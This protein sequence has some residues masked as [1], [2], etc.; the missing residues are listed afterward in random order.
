MML[1]CAKWQPDGVVH[2]RGDRGL[3]RRTTNHAGRSTPLFGPGDHD[4]ADA[5][6]RVPP[7]SAADR[8]ADRL[9]HSPARSRSRYPRPFH[10][11]PAG[12]DAGGG[13]T[14][15]QRRT[16]ASVGGQHWVE[17][18]WRRR[19]VGREARY[20]PAPVVAETAHRC[21]CRH[22]PDRRGDDPAGV[23]SEEHTSELQSPCNLVCRLLLEKK[24]NNIFL[25]YT[26]T[27][28]TYHIRLT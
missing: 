14:A 7:G 24:K 23:R 25:T 8:R 16:R 27:N 10:A 5:A 17:A 12:R 11:E 19:M 21:R 4:G 18:V 13:G 22:R 2:R 3:A 1:P 15:I 9:R 26:V 6:R 20:E 28:H